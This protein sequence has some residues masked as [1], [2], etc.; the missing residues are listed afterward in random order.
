MPA[1]PDTC[2]SC[3]SRI[4]PDAIFC[5]RCGSEVRREGR[6]SASGGAPD[7]ARVQPS[8]EGVAVEGLPLDDLLSSRGALPIPLV[9]S[10][11]RQV[12]EALAHMHAPPRGR[13][14]G[15]IRP[16][17]IRV[18]RGGKATLGESGTRGGDPWGG[19]DMST[20]L[21]LKN[22][23]YLS[24]EE[25]R[26][27]NPTPSSDQYAMGA[28]AYAMLAGRPPFVG[29]FH[30]V[31]VAHLSEAFVPLLQMRPDCPPRLAYAVERMLSKDP[32]DRWSEV[33]EALE[34]ALSGLPGPLPELDINR[35]QGLD[36][37]E[38][39]DRE[40]SHGAASGDGEPAGST[41]P[42]EPAVDSAAGSR[43]GSG[44]VPGR[45]DP[46]PDLGP[47]PTRPIEL[48]V[49]ALDEEEDLLEDDRRS[50]FFEPASPPPAQSWADEPTEE[51]EEAEGMMALVPSPPVRPSA[52]LRGPALPPPGR[53][54]RPRAPPRRR[55]RTAALLLLILAGGAGWG[56]WERFGPSF[57]ATDRPG[58]EGPANGRFADALLEPDDSGTMLLPAPEA[59][60][61]SRPARG[62]PTPSSAPPSPAE[63]QDPAASPAEAT[64][65][66]LRNTLLAAAPE[67]EPTPTA[68]SPT[69]TARPQET[70]SPPQ[71]PAPVALGSLEMNIR[72]WSHVL[73]N[74]VPR[75]RFQTRVALELTAGTH[76]IRMSNPNFPPF[77]TTVVIQGGETTVL[78]KVLQPDSEP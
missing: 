3:F 25:C 76:F 26:G 56:T 4:Q 9:E 34:A 54:L 64:A 62:E 5:S 48:E 78:N 72:P 66:L 38:S 22:T 24:P 16:E 13:L 59:A 42:E 61:R 28:V 19:P 20:G 77:D 65:P 46:G 58:T 2:P 8:V 33:A 31:L 10:I 45:R 67:P 15:N 73:V 6:G 52:T 35:W 63:A 11:L 53:S 14:H 69:Q 70:R 75:G 74:G 71:E 30:R 36:R 37:S 32:A 7:A 49:D 27:L 60:A 47:P 55:Q 57:E 21:V 68:P 40:P 17:T 44:A 43:W 50:L 23:E 18:E 1:I 29:A 39:P 51:E 12:G 41:P